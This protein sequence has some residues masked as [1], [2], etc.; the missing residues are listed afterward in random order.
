VGVAEGTLDYCYQE[1]K[2]I[3]G[4]G[5]LVHRLVSSFTLFPAA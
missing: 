2:K 1:V 3:L 4:T 5:V